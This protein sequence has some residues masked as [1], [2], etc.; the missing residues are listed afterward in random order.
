[1][2][3]KNSNESMLDI[4]TFETNQL[5]E[6]LEQLIIA[7]EA[8]SKL[9]T[10]IDEI[11]RIVHTIKGSSSMM[12][13]NNIAE[14]AHALEDLL[15]YLKEKKF[16]A[17]NYTTLSDI[18]LE[19]VDFVK[20]EMTKVGDGITPDG[21]SKESI[22]RIKLLLDELNASNIETKGIQ[23]KV[24]NPC[25][26]KQLCKS[27]KENEYE[28]IVYFV[29]D[30]QMENVRAFGVI[31]NLSKTCD[32]ISYIPERLS[33]DEGTAEEYIRRNGFTMKFFSDDSLDEIRAKLMETIFLRKLELRVVE[34]EKT[35]LVKRE[36]CSDEAG[37]GTVDQHEPAQQEVDIG[38]RKNVKLSHNQNIMSVNTS[39][40]D[41]LMDLIG[42]LVIAESM[43]T[44]NPALS[45]IKSDSFNQALRFLQKIT[46]EL[47]DAVM[48]T[49]MVPLTATF[50]K[51]NRLVRDVSHKLGKEVELEII[52]ETTEIDKNVIEHLADPLMHIIRN[53]LDHG[54]EDAPERISKGKQKKGKIVL[55]AKNEG[56]NVWIHIKDD[57]R[58]LDKGKIVKKAIERGLIT[59][60]E[61]TDKEIYE[62]VLLPGFSTKENVTEF[63][64]RGVGMDVVSKK[65]GEIGGS[66]IIDSTKDVGTVIALKI[67]LTLAII[68]GMIIRVG[69]SK[70][71]VPTASVKET[72]QATH[73]NI[74]S[75]PNGNELIFLRGE[76]YPIIRLHN[77]F[78]AQA[79]TNNIH[80]GILVIAESNTRSVCIFAD[81]IMGQQQIV[82]KPI[83]KLIKKINGIAGCALLGDGSISLIIDVKDFA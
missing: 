21:N 49:R 37:K 22:T 25:A 5:V 67:P 66:V 40:M 33:E 4:Y 7:G 54:I 44:K 15:Y 83:P 41:K 31:H 38:E 63:S 24:E 46:L 50:Q 74:V 55:E 56:G 75:D 23:Q 17:I 34:C 62:L 60:E 28:A 78:N 45:Q 39:K 76:C 73:E 30:C 14:L 70:Y 16:K 72:L 68:D 27:K 18:I 6:Q 65:I 29:E 12:N 69:K 35:D 71:I 51:M 2:F 77:I 36:E 11:F 57:G 43:V 80:K 3:E 64:G 53:S 1:M 26:I 10:S 82:V 9:E 8:S 32:I 58:G 61:I 20:L 13:F 48:S 52:G 79:D 59:R 19:V 42:E 47:Q 81:E